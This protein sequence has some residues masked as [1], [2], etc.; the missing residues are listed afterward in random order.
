M[1]TQRGQMKQ[2]LK[3]ARTAARHIQ[4]R[5]NL[6]MTILHDY[7]AFALGCEVAI[8]GAMELETLIDELIKNQP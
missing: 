2:E 6:P 8:K 4:Q 7:E 3:R 5:L 1:A